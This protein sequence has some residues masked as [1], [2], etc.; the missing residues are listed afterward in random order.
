MHQLSDEPRLCKLKTHF[1]EIHFTETNEIY[2]FCI[3]TPPRRPSKQI[4]STHCTVH[5]VQYILYCMNIGILSDHVCCVRLCSWC[6]T[7]IAGQVS[8]DVNGDRNGDFSLMAMT[9]VETGAY[10]VRSKIDRLACVIPQAQISVFVCR[11]SFCLQV[12]ANYFGVNGTFQLL[13]AFS[14]DHF[15]LRGRH[16]TD[17]EIPDKSCKYIIMK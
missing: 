17:T 10:E 9:N 16:K 15:T 13:P 14:P 12:V 4:Y 5:T 8:M 2:A 7:G 3:C 1:V 6:W 11:S